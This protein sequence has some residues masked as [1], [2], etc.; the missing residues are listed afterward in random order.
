MRYNIFPSVLSGL[1]VA[2]SQKSA[3]NSTWKE[4]G[5]HLDNYLFRREAIDV[6]A[7]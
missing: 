6:L 4:Y 2:L 5:Q 3:R 1:D 7:F